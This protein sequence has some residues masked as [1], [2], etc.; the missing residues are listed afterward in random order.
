M[1]FKKTKPDFYTVLRRR[2]RTVTGFLAELGIKTFAELKTL[3]ASL[4][5]M[6][7]LSEKF[8][9]EAHAFI[10]TRKAT[11]QATTEASEESS[12]ATDLEGGLK[13]PKSSLRKSKTKRKTS[14]TKKREP[15]DSDSE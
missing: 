4:D 12:S 2:R 5:G 10:T 1:A 9:E 11:T 14:P 13:N 6:Y 3:L 7:F 15:Q 8:N